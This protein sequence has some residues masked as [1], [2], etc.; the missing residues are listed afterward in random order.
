[1]EAFDIELADDISER[2]GS[3]HDRGKPRR[4]RNPRAVRGD[5][6]TVAQAAAAVQIGVARSESDPESVTVELGWAQF[7]AQYFSN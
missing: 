1:V 3:A 5:R 2:E 6:K 7:G 4:G